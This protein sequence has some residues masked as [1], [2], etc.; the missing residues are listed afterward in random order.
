M[1]GKSIIGPYLLRQSVRVS[2]S[3][4]YAIYKIRGWRFRVERE[5]IPGHSFPGRHGLSPCH[6]FGEPD[7]D[8]R[9]A[10]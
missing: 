3:T 1:P 2:V 9:Q 6:T 8:T 5:Q 7:P 10:E 4:V